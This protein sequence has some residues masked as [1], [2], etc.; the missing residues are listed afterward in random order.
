M[1]TGSTGLRGVRIAAAALLVLTVT[2]TGCGRPPDEAWLRCLGFQQSAA[3]ISVLEGDLNDETSSTVDIELENSSQV[4]G[5]I[6]GTGILVNRTRIDYRMSGFSPPS[7]DYPVNLYLSPPAEGKPTTGTLTAFP[8]ASKSLKQWLIDAGVSDPV[9]ELTAR[10]TFYGLTDEGSQIETEASLGIALTNTGVTEETKPTLTIKKE[11]DVSKAAAGAT[12]AFTVFRSGDFTINLTIEFT[13]SG[14]PRAG[15]NYTL[16]TP[17][18]IPAL[19]NS[20]E[21]K[22]T[23]IGATGSVGATGTVTIT[24]SPNAAYKVGSPSSASLKITD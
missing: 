22:V 13:S 6:P 20:V 2:V 7:A 16:N 9:V 5:R 17:V 1:T 19:S 8:L 4:V 21:I 24:L 14:T 18:V 11:R 12:G 3:T 10:V 23:P 15:V